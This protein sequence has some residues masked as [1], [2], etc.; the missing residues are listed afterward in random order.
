[1]AVVETLLIGYVYNPT[2][3]NNAVLTVGKRRINGSTEII[4]AFG[5]DEAKEL[6]EKLV[7]RKV[8]PEA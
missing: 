4:N 7:T 8:I 5:G 3:A 1:M 6:Y 2:K